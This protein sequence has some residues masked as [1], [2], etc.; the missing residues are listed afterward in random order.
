LSLDFRSYANYDARRLRMSIARKSFLIVTV[1]LAFQV[2]F[3][4][5]FFDAERRSAAHRAWQARSTE[6]ALSAGRLLG[7]VN[8]AESAVR[9]FAIS[10]NPALLE[11]YRR[12]IGRLPGELRELERLS[13]G[14]QQNADAHRV[15][16]ID[17]VKRATEAAWKHLQ[18]ESG[19]VGSGRLDEALG[20]LKNDTTV[21]AIDQFRRV[22]RGYQSEELAHQRVEHFELESLA[23]TTRIEAIAFVAVNVALALALI[24]FLQHVAFRRRT[25]ITLHQRRAGR[26]RTSRHAVSRNGCPAR[27]RAPG[28]PGP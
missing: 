11:I 18:Q 7:I 10:G 20:H 19:V 2:L 3:L 21:G 12:A 1:P 14:S 28:A 24:W 6:S 15:Y 16:R 9:G 17:D 4:V 13:A 22:A 27:S 5:M 23:R 25:D 26:D 8:D